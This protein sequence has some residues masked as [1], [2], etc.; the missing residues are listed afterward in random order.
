VVKKSNEKRTKIEVL[1]DAWM[2]YIDMLHLTTYRSKYF[3]KKNGYTDNMFSYGEVGAITRYLE[4]KEL[5]KR[6]KEG[7]Y[8]VKWRKKRGEDHGKDH[9]A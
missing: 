7:T 9:N 3:T 5:I 6:E 8:I 1:A 2:D 4:K